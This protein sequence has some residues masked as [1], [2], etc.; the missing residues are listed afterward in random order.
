MWLPTVSQPGMGRDDLPTLLA[1]STGGIVRVRVVDDV[2]HLRRRVTPP[3]TLGTPD[4][5]NATGGG[6]AVGERVYG[7]ASPGDA[8]ALR[9]LP[10]IGVAGGYGGAIRG[11][12]PGT[13]LH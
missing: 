5:P 13:N 7:R 4:T 1:R 10:M 12:Q 3:P 2:P 9:G 6:V 8:A 11:T